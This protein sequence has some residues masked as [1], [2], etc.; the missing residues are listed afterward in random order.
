[1]NLKINFLIIIMLIINNNFKIT[2]KS[3]NNNN[4]Q[5]IKIFKSPIVK[6]LKNWHKIIQKD[7]SI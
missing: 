4:L 6:N 3:N 5:T 7:I 2:I 1:M